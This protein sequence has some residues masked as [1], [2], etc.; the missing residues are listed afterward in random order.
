MIQPKKKLMNANCNR[1]MTAAPPLNSK[2]LNQNEIFKTKIIYVTMKLCISLESARSHVHSKIQL[3][4]F[5]FHYDE[6]QILNLMR[7]Q[8]LQFWDLI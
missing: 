6:I 7:T 5:H 4:E 8:T 1:G 2:H 3:K